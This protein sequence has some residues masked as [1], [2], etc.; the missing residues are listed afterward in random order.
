MNSKAFSSLHIKFPL[1][2]NLASLGYTEMTPVQAHSLPLILAGKDLIVK[3]KTGSGKTA[4]F[5]I[6]LLTHLDPTTFTLQAL[7]LCPTREL[8]DQVGRELRRLARFTDN[9]KILTICGGVPFGPQL[10]S[11][12][13]GAHILVGTPGRLLDH[14]RRGT[15]NLSGLRTLVLDEA[16]RM[17][18][19]GFQEDI[20]TLIAATPSK[21][22]TLL[23]SAT[24][25]ESIV[26]MSAAIQHE[27]I[28]VSVD[29]AHDE[30]TIEQVFYEVNREDRIVAVARI[31][32]HYS[33]ESTLVF[34]NTKQ[35]CQEL[36]A[37]LASSGFA[38]LAIHGDLEQRERDQVLARFANRSASVLVATDVAAR[39]LDIKE[40]PLV[41]NFELSRNPEIHTHR[42][43]RTGRA[44]EQGLAISLV[45]SRENR[46]VASIEESLGS[47]ISRNDIASLGAAPGR[48]APPSM[49]TICI[50]GGRKNKL[51]PGDILGA[52]TG[53][54]GIAGSEVGR[55][56]IFEHYTYVAIVRQSVTQALDCLVVNR[57]K[58]RFFRVRR[59]S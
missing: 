23:F 18:D 14:L 17:L 25:P 1:L 58:G 31:L 55:I 59:V 15:L 54:G 36:A 33:P 53:E 16:D 26:A 2:K 35:E 3:A 43:G 30:G 48:P 50:D 9:I 13:H 39:G 29:E 47:T 4:A 24:Y 40:L 56:D 57:I 46:Q 22:Q 51:R 49:V 6:G 11:L 8:A 38:A 41:I 19:M 20:S 5:G 44:G 27:P 32:G 52:L 28:E 34:C 12:E 45:T 21:R 10:G 37:A 7:V 42:I